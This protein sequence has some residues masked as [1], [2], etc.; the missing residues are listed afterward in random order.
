MELLKDVPTYEKDHAMFLVVKDFY[1]FGSAVCGFKEGE[2]KDWQDC[3]L[4]CS[5][6]QSNPL[7]VVSLFGP[8]PLSM[9]NEYSPYFLCTPE[10]LLQI[11]VTRDCPGTLF[12][13]PMLA[14]CRERY[15]N[16]PY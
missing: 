2:D 3:Q 6:R 1:K 9:Y 16:C 15:A 14:Y 5:L 8:E 7:Q 13:E 11:V 12:P 10:E 4:R